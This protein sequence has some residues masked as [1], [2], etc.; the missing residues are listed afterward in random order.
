MTEN[1]AHGHAFVE[2]V[3]NMYASAGDQAITPWPFMVIQGRINS[4]LETG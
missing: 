3:A 2:V 1:N 4:I